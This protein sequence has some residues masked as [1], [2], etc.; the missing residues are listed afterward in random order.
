[1]T[2]RRT[3]LFHVLAVRLKVGKRARSEKRDMKRLRFES[4]FWW[5]RLPH[6]GENLVISGLMREVGYNA[7]W[8]AERLGLGERTFQR[9]VNDSLGVSPGVWLRSERAV[10]AR[11]RLAAG[12]SV[13]Q[14]ANI[15]G[16][17]HQGDFSADFRR[18]HGINPTEHQKL[19][20][21]RR[22]LD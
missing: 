3:G 12:C 5:Y 7:T 14:L 13:K 4:G 1:M 11:H 15:Y 19:A 8:L 20:R 6:G 16:F 2:I 21:S 17:K 18:L 10:D 22:R 9:I